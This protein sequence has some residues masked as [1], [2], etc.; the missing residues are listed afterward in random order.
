MELS[1]EH[2]LLKH[3]FTC[4]VAGPTMCGKS[5]FVQRL[6]TYAEEI[7]DPAPDRIVWCYGGETWQE[8]FANFPNV[9]FISGLNFTP[10]SSNSRTL[11]IIDDLMCETDEKVTKIFTRG[12]HHSNLS[13]VYIVQNLFHKGKEQRTISLNSNYLVMFKNPRDVSQITHLAKQ[14]SPGNTKAVNEAYVDAT[15][16][17]FGYL[18]FD[19]KPT[20]PEELRLRTNIFPNENHIVY[21]IK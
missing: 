5:F 10:N 11:L 4:L 8:S 19:F 1:S 3:P 12:S 13:V 20:T 21:L 2:L 7:I 18:F 6:I 9:E 14:I 15:H 16:T 17:P